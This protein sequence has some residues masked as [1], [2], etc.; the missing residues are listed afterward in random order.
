MGMLFICLLRSAMIQIGHSFS[1]IWIG[2][3][4]LS[5]SFT[6]ILSMRGCSLMLITR[7]KKSPNY[8]NISY[9]PIERG[10]RIG[11]AAVW[12]WIWIGVLAPIWSKCGA[13]PKLHKSCAFSVTHRLRVVCNWAGIFEN[14]FFIKSNKSVI[15]ECTCGHA[16]WTQRQV[17]SLHICQSKSITCMWLPHCGN[18][19]WA[20]NLRVLSSVQSCHNSLVCLDTLWDI[21]LLVLHHCVVTGLYSSSALRFCAQSLI[22]P[23][24]WYTRYT[25]LVS[26]ERVNC[27]LGFGRKNLRVLY[28]PVPTQ[29]SHKLRSFTW[30]SPAML[31]KLESR[32][33][34]FNPP[35]EWMRTNI[36]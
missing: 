14:Q 12:D 21:C 19:L 16:R 34:L 20:Q 4:W 35:G 10:H 18:R 27:I 22:F 5:V 8:G 17:A 9:D 28:N 1:F 26:S 25:T 36:Q 3:I 6:N 23:T 30:T 2:R 13:K 31:V 11:F 33:H 15:F 24:T 29:H 7:D 32:F